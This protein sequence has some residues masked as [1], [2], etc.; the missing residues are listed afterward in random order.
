M[1]TD[2]STSSPQ[3]ATAP[4]AAAAPVDA[5]QPTWKRIGK[6]ILGYAVLILF[7]LAF[8]MPFA[9]AIATS[10]KTRAEVQ[11]NPLGLIPQQVTFEAYRAMAAVDLPRW[12]FNSAVVTT[13]VTLGRL[14]LDS[15]AGY[16]LA[17]LKFPGRAAVFALVVGVLAVPGIVLAIPRFIVLGQLGL[18][19]SYAG[20]ILPLA[21]D[22][23]GIF[24]MKQFFESIPKEMEEAARMDGA[25]IFQTF[26]RIILPLAAPG[27][28]A[29][30]ILSFQGSW[31]EFLHP[32]IAAP[33][34][35]SLRTLPVGLALLRGAGGEQL[36]FPLLMAGSLLT[37]IPVAIIFF[38]FQ[39]YFIS[40]VAA[41]GVKG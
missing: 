39:R 19:N 7:A 27:L 37:T 36:D 22:A 14:F 1:S 13:F 4:A 24:L 40:G 3:P 18:L 6:R 2:I 31:N 12:A 25:T 9:L 35:P 5:G 15:L 38:T 11:A 21:V 41:S 26:W 34:D 32:L 8:I 23:F 33:S 20:L 30:T 28:I 17:R 16:A 29:L 10:F